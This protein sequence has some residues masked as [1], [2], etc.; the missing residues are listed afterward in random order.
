MLVFHQ[1]LA[2]MILQAFSNLSDPMVL[3]FYQ[4]EHAHGDRTSILI[5]TSVWSKWS[6]LAHNPSLTLSL[7]HQT[8]FLFL[9]AMRNPLGFRK[10][11]HTDAPKSHL[12]QYWYKKIRIL[13]IMGVL[14]VKILKQCLGPAYSMCNFGLNFILPLAL[15]FYNTFWFNQDLLE[16]TWLYQRAAFVLLCC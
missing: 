6:F 14:W 8:G 1:K 11:K 9:N 2:L 16:F 4:R 12:F 7:G 15:N 10:I 5:P 13:K 3:W